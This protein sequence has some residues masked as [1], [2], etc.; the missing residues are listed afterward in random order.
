M[1]SGKETRYR[2]ELACTFACKNEIALNVWGPL[3]WESCTAL[4]LYVC[5]DLLLI[6]T[7]D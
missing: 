6:G 1:K 4:S 7:L 2:S 3:N 5:P